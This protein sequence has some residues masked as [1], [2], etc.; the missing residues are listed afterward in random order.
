ME[1]FSV[2]TD[3]DIEMPEDLSSPEEK[4]KDSVSNGRKSFFL[5]FFRRYYN[6]SSL[7][8]SS[9]SKLRRTYGL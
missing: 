9:F 8:N 4:P 5:F 2:S 6:F 7:I 1:T 3:H